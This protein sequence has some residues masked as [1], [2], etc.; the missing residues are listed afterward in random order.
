MKTGEDLEITY[1]SLS[2]V[3]VKKD[4]VVNQNDV[5]GLAGENIYNK[6]LGIH[7][8]VVVQKD[9]KLIDPATVIGMKPAEIK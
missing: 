6:D 1:Q 2:Q 8:H 3:S 7:L 4:Q 5:L 9:G